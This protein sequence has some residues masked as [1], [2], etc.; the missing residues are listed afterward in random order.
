MKTLIWLLLSLC[1]AVWSGLCWF[2]YEAIGFSGRF[3]ARNAD[4]VG[5]DAETVEQFSSWAL[6]A[7]S[8]GEWAVLGVWGIGT[9][10]ALVLGWLANKL[11][12]TAK[13]QLDNQ[14]PR[15]PI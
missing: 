14:P 11:L 5:P 1:I 12:R 6:W 4:A 3:A 10:I 13:T 8:F 7:A 9:F 15:S 2:A